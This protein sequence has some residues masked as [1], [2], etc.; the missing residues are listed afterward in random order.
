MNE[1]P[2]SR[3]VVVGIDG[4]KAAIQAAL[5]AV[6]EAVSRDV[7]LRLLYAIEQGDAQDAE[8]GCQARKLATAETAVRRAVTA[9]EATGTA[10]K[11]RDRDRQG[12][13]DRVVDPRVGISGH[14]VRG[15]GRITPLSSRAGWVPPLRLWPFRRG[16]RWRLFAATTT[17]PD[18]PRMGSS[19]RWTGLP[20]TVYCWAPPWR[21]P[22]CATPTIR[23]VICRP[24]GVGRWRQGD[25][26]AIAGHSPTS[27]A[28][29]PVGGDAIRTSGSSRWP[30]T[31][32]FWITWLTT[33][34]RWGW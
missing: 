14:G 25:S 32:A 28:G 22:G 24:D 17:S 1:L 10:G 9:I 33:A 15:R 7:P 30:C 4:S 2:T 16:A 12:A 5:W 29:W 6:D 23:A 27:I 21:K 20:T 19:S 34:D 8:R 26:T 3:P 13:A 31:A 11:D 18:S